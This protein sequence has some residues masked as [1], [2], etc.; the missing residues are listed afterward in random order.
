MPGQPAHRA[1]LTQEAFEIIRV[2][3]SG[4]HLDCDGP[5]K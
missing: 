4:E 1:L 5:L 2:E 3:V